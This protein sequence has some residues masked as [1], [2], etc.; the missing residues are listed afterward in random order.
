MPQTFL[1]YNGQVDKL[2]N[3]KDLTVNDRNYAIQMLTRYG[4]FSL[5]G[6]Y[7]NIF[8]N[9]SVRKYKRGTTFEDIVNLYRFDEELRSLFLKNILKFE[10]KLHSVI[11]YHFTQIYGEKQIFY[12]D[13]NN[14][15]YIP[16]YRQ[17]IDELIRKL[18]NLANGS[19]DYAYIKYHKNKYGNVPLWVLINAV[20]LGMVS[21]F[22]M[23]SKP[24]LQSKISINFPD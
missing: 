14:Y 23:Y 22:Y 6:G 16:Q 3:E 12:L 18:S 9:R 8:I 19:T 20:T 7:K 5:I 13:R 10:R 21:R 4:Y 1:D 11:S 24:G 15:N 17:G 2:V